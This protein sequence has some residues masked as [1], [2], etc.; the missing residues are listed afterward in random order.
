MTNAIDDAKLEQFKTAILNLGIDQLLE[1]RDYCLEKLS[2][3]PAKMARETYMYKALQA[4]ETE[5]VG[6]GKA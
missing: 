4:L 5:M 2:I 6:R 1:Y 3:L